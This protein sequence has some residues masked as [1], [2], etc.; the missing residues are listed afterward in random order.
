MGSLRKMCA[1]TTS[2]R[3]QL[4]LA[5]TQQN[6]YV[7]VGI[8]SVDCDDT[9]YSL[10]LIVILGKR[11]MFCVERRANSDWPILH[12]KLVA[13]VLDF[14]NFRIGRFP[15]QFYVVHVGDGFGVFA[16]IAYDTGPHAPPEGFEPR[17]G[18]HDGRQ[19]VLPC[20]LL[21]VVHSAAEINMLGELCARCKWTWGED[22]CTEALAL[23]GSYGDGVVWMVKSGEGAMVGR[24]AASCK[25]KMR[26]EML[27]YSGDKL[28]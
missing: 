22:D 25:F 12:N 9:H 17:V 27:I 16:I 14:S 24:L 28:E 7:R 8:Y 3:R 15:S 21:H 5:Y 19:Q 18:V 20:M 1:A 26:N 4:S 13:L 6:T 2:W 10:V 11:V 23:D